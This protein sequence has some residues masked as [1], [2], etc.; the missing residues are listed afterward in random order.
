MRAKREERNRWI[1]GAI[2]H[3][4]SLHKTLGIPEGKKIPEKRLEKATH[5]RSPITKKRAILAETLRNFEHK[6]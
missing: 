4:G 3:P 2:E 5:S 6:K 1:Q